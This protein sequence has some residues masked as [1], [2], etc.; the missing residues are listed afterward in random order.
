MKRER[1]DQLLRA[2]LVAWALSPS[3]LTAATYITWLFEAGGGEQEA[4]Q[5]APPVRVQASLTKH[6]DAHLADAFERA[7]RNITSGAQRMEALARWQS[8]CG[9]GA[10]AYLSVLPTTDTSLQL[11]ADLQREAMRRQLGIERP[12]PGVSAPAKAAVI[13]HRA[14]HTP[15]RALQAASSIT[16]TTACAGCW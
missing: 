16:A 9:K 2:D 4:A 3:A 8:Q 14:G 6:T 5:E 7:L 12:N 11:D 13:L 15:A 1:L 10:C